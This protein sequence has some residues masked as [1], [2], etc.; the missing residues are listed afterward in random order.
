MALEEESVEETEAKPRAAD[1]HQSQSWV[2]TT[3]NQALERSPAAGQ[4]WDFVLSC[5]S[6]SAAGLAQST[7]LSA[8]SIPD[9]ADYTKKTL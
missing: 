5:S 2:K 3:V 1:L 8:D 4:S 6:C 7:G 9:A